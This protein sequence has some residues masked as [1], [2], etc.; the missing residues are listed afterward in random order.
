MEKELGKLKAELI[1]SSESNEEK[2]LQVS[3]KTSHCISLAGVEAPRA[4]LGVSEAKLM[5]S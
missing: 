4:S 3:R 2:V 5:I 1:V